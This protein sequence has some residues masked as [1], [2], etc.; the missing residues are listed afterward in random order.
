MGCK[1]RKQNFSL[2]PEYTISGCSD[3]SRPS[4]G[5]QLVL[6]LAITKIIPPVSGLHKKMSHRCNFVNL[7]QPAKAD[8]GFGADPFQQPTNPTATR[9]SGSRFR[10]VG[11][12]ATPSRRP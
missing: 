3:P 2:S 5:D 9:W 8:S 1:R 11:A 12:A 10:M 7:P 6:S 4:A